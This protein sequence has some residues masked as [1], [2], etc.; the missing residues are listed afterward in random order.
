MTTGAAHQIAGR[1]E[2]SSTLSPCRSPD[3]CSLTRWLVI[4]KMPQDHGLLWLAQRGL[5]TNLIGAN[6]EV[7]F[8]KKI[9]KALIKFDGHAFALLAWS[10]T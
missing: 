3:C 4:V 8:L 7:V 1:T 2:V 6:L 9:Q 5:C 10:I